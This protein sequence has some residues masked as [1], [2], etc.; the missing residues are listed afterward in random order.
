MLPPVRTV[1][2]LP[3]QRSYRLKI[4]PGLL[5]RLGQECAELNLATRCAIISDAN[6]RPRF[7]PA[8]QRAL[9]EAGFDA[10]VIAVPAGERAKSLRTVEDCYNK[11][12]AHRLERK[13]FLVAL[14]GGVVGDLAGFVAASYLRGIPFVQVPTTLLGQVD[15]SVGGKVGVNLKAGKNLVGAFHQPRLVLCD[16]ATLSSLPMR[17]YRAGLAEVIKYG[18]ISDAALFRRLERELPKLLAREPKTLAAIVV[19]CCEIK[20]EVVRQDETESGLR[21]I[22]NFGHTIGHALEAISH[23]GKYLHGEAI[24]IGQVAAAQLSA[25]VLGLSQIDVERIRSL[26]ERAGLPTEVKLNR[27]QLLKLTAAMSLDKKVAA[28]EIKFVLARKIGEV[29]FGIRIP[30]K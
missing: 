25:Q 18:I 19:R 9:T 16:L 6:V 12:A 2:V 21:A 20:A 23:Y 15:S 7:A 17:E 11:L 29:K 10:V 1:N 27:S 5:A 30:E 3:G 22:L 24:S 14:G 8:A 4:A 28:G 26:F 13:S